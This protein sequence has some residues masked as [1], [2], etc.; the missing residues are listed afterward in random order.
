MSLIGLLLALAAI[1]GGNMI[2][3]GHPSALLDL[4]AFLIVIGGTVGAALTQFPFSVV[5]KTLKRFKW[6]ITPLR[7][8]MLEQAQLLETLAGNAR[9]SGMLALEGMIDDIKDPQGESVNIL[10]N[11]TQFFETRIEYRFQIFTAHSCD[12]LLPSYARLA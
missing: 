4:P 6:L 11:F 2:E 8:D 5:G 12:F 1:L 3:G 7:L 10:L 9:R